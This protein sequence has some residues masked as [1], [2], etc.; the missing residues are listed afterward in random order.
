MLASAKPICLSTFTRSR[1]ALS[2]TSLGALECARESPATTSAAQES[3]GPADAGAANKAPTKIVSIR[4]SARLVIWSEV[5]GGGLCKRH[6][7]LVEMVVVIFVA[8][9]QGQS[10]VFSAQPALYSVVW[11]GECAGI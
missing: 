10:G 8:G 11:R 9:S 4:K 7:A 1:R 3:N 2:K 5:G 6:Q